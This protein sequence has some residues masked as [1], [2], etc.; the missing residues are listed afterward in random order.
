MQ[1]VLMKIGT[2]SSQLAMIQAFCVREALC[3]AHGM[4]REQIEIVPMSTKGDRITDRPLAQIGGKGLFTQ[5]IEQALVQGRID[6]AVHS[7]KD[8]PT[9]L[10]EGLQLGHFLP[11]EDPRD[12]FVAKVQGMRIDKLPQGACLGTSSL[13]RGA[14]IRHYRPDLTIVPLR[15]NVETRLSKLQKG[16]MQGTF[17]SLAGLKRLG[18]EDVISEILEKDIMLPAP[19]QGAIAI[20]SRIH[21]TRIAGFL[22]PVGCS[23][24]YDILACERSF[25]AALDGSCRTPLGGLA[26]ITSSDLHFTGAIASPDGAIYHRVEMT[27]KRDEAIKIGRVAA[28][29]LRRDAGENFFDD[30][31]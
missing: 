5:E 26:Q 4:G 2:R 11:R 30:W 3:Q 6:I 25:L 22:T 12:V 24:T 10:P 1:T 28:A 27:G 15:G 14:F 21:D 29:K 7:T 20:E 9:L 16:Q 13:R 31:G 23:I 8:M 17:L 19:G 18:Q